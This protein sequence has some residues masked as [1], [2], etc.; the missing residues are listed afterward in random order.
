MFILLAALGA[1]L[2]SGAA[3]RPVERMRAD[4][5]RI[6]EHDLDN[7]ISI[8]GTADELARLASTFNALLDRIRVSVER[9]RNLVA[10]AGHELRT[11]LAILRTE[12]ELADKP[13]RSRADLADAITHARS[14]V[15]RLTRLAADLLFLARADGTGG[16]VQP[17]DT[18]VTAQLVGAVRAS[19]GRAEAVGVTLQ[20]DAPGELWMLID[21]DALRRAL[22]N[23][24]ANAIAATPSNGLVTVG[25]AVVDHDRTIWVAD[26]GPG[27]PPDFLPVR[28]RPVPTGRLVALQRI[29]RSRAGTFHCGG[30]R[31]G[32]RWLRLGVQQPGRRSHCHH[33]V[34][35]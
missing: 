5:E 15:D 11:P 16:I 32:P 26:T 7:R 4:A 13:D 20:I 6:G 23:L 3:L 29:G 27:F 35:A 14:E 1:W 33:A 22:D 19:R 8:P 28:V 21:P 25:A 18:D 10:D 24:V 31:G 9:Q 17:V 30:D 12:L 2:L 34:P